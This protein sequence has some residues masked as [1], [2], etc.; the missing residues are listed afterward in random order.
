MFSQ[1]NIPFQ[2]RQQALIAEQSLSPDPVLKPDQSKIEY[3]VSDDEANG[4][5]SL[6]RIDVRGMD[7]RIVRVTANNLLE[8]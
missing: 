5:S 3:S 8:S 1:L 4:D 7:D 6:L 2:N